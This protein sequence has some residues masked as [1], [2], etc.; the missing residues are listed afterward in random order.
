MDELSTCVKGYEQ[1]CQTRP[2]SV[3]S[4]SA[5]PRSYPS[6]IVERY[7]TADPSIFVGDPVKLFLGLSS[8]VFDTLFFVQHYCL[9]TDRAEPT[10]VPA[11]KRGLLT[12]EGTI[13]YDDFDY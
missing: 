4:R 2:H 11:E 13:G 8:I 3:I 9:Y 10:V 1:R 6:H 5:T 7:N 12:N